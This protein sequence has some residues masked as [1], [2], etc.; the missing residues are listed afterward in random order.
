MTYADAM[1]KLYGDNPVTAELI[2]HLITNSI[3]LIGNLVNLLSD[4]DINVIREATQSEDGKNRLHALVEHFFTELDLLSLTKVG[5]P[6][7]PLFDKAGGLLAAM[8]MTNVQLL[9]EGYANDPT[10]SDPLQM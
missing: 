1:T 6:D 2:A 7:V 8:L 9:K 5:Q 3:D 4:S 10:V